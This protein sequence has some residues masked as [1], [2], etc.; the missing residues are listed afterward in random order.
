MIFAGVAQ[1]PWY[2]RYFSAS[3]GE[4]YAFL[5][6]R[7]LNHVVGWK[8]PIGTSD[9]LYYVEFFASIVTAGIFYIRE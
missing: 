4:S 5:Y 6:L 2:V 8:D 1:H 3:N 7:S 9:R